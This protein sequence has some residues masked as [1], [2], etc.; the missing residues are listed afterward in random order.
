MPCS[1]SA[2]YCP[3]CNA[4]FPNKT[5]C[6]QH[7]NQPNGC[8]HA[9]FH[10]AALKAQRTLTEKFNLHS[11]QQKHSAEVADD[12]SLDIDDE[13]MDTPWLQ[14][15]DFPVDEPDAPVPHNGYHTYAEECRATGN[16]H[17]LFTSPEE[18]ELALF[19]SRSNMSIAAIDEF[20]KLRLPHRDFAPGP[21]WNALPWATVN[22]TKNPL[23]LYYRDPLECLQELLSNPLVSDFIHFTPFRM[24]ATAE[25]LV[26]IYTE[27]LSADAAWRIQ[28]KIPEGAT[29][30]GTVLSSNKTQLTSMTRNR[31]AHPLLISLADID[32][33]FRMKA[34][35]HAFLLLALLPIAKSRE[36][37]PEIR[38]VLGS[39][40]F[41][42][43]LDFVLQPLKKTT[44]IGA[45][46]TDPLSWRRFCFTPIAAYITHDPWDLA[47][48]VKAA[49]QRH[50]NGVHRPFWRDW[51]LA[52]PF[53]FLTPE[54][55]HHWL[56]F[57]YD[58]LCKWCIEAVGA[59]EIDF[60]FSV[61]RLHTGMRHFKEGISKGKQTT[62]REHHDIQRYI[63][64]VIAGVSKPFLTA[65]TSLN[66]FFYHGQAPVI[67]DDIL[68]KMS[69]HLKTFHK[70]KEAILAAG[71][72][73]GKKGPINNWYIPKLE[74]LQSVIPA[75]RANGVPLQWSADVTEH[76]HITLVKDPASNSN[77]QNYES[78]ICRHLDRRD[79]CRRFDLT[80]AIATAGLDFGACELGDGHMVDHTSELLDQIEPVARLS[81]TDQPNLT[82]DATATRFRLS[83]LRPALAEYLHRP[84]TSRLVIGGRR[85]RLK[86]E[87]LPFDKLEVWHNLRI[88]NHA[89]HDSNKILI[90]ET[91]N[92][93]PPD[94]NWICGRADPV[95]V[96]SDSEVK[97]PQNG[98]EGHT[99][100]QLRMI[101]RVVPWRDSQPVSGTSRFLAYVQRFD[102][103]NQTDPATNMSGPIPEPASGMYH[104]KRARRSDQSI[105]GDIVLL[106]RLRARIELTPRFGK[107]A[108]RR[109]TKETSLDYCD[110]FWL[111]KWFTKELFFALSH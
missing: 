73:K 19:L 107:A 90:P 81:G 101:F 111:S 28:D 106:D 78:Q 51:P 102:V 86:D 14:D 8:C 74:F 40:L 21:T 2:H 110:D 52:E 22:P 82:V 88:Q 104:L 103:V 1:K 6:L 7:L 18:W 38:G 37:N 54:V 9:A 35:H 92:T 109:L 12:D 46:M 55:L 25:K 71:V 4:Y 89:F 75:I 43:I 99:I 30:L 11:R 44:E 49:K 63:I 77:N 33:E 3:I 56:K 87:R 42:S 47:S 79:K 69:D 24:W 95:L 61:L 26:W 76:A 68:T 83:D 97:W 98:L 50:L 66:N 15:L 39:R 57:F 96:N 91:I 20:R 108:D 48:Y 100:C 105:M 5:R 27:W 31:Q 72:R 85:P 67:N 10:P 16:I 59:V 58:H 84:L 70:N 62:G 29:V 80:T 94:N 60:R 34:S 36:K 17:Y 65:I 93:D 13:P 41:H 53:E 32:M 23:T 45:M 64:P